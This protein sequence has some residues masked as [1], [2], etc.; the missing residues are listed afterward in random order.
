MSA[1]K[2]CF[3]VTDKL[4]QLLHRQSADRDQMITAIETLL[5]QRETLLADV[6][7][8]FTEE[9]QK[10]GQEIIKRN[11]VIDMELKKLKATIQKDM[12]SLTKK[13][14]SVDKYVNP[15]ASMQMD[16]VFYDRKN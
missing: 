8:P 6:K 4:F 15:Y 2:A 14:D 12:Q 7:A 5:E 10:L 3:D 9:E 16:G 13:K 1:V 11:A